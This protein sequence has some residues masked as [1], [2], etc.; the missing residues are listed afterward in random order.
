MRRIFILIACLFAAPAWGF[1]TKAGPLEIV[2]DGNGQKHLRVGSKAY[3][4]PTEPSLAF[5]EAQFDDW[6]LILVSQGGNAC[7]G[8]YLWFHAVPGE[9]GF[10]PDFGTC[11]EAAEVSRRA[12]GT[13]AVTMPRASAGA[14]PVTYLWDGR[15]L[16][17][18]DAARPVSGAAPGQGA[19]YWID[20]YPFD[21]LAAADYQDRIAAAMDDTARAELARVMELASPFEAE[22]AWIVGAGCVKAACDSDRAVIALAR[23]DGRIVVALRSPALGAQLFGNPGGPLPA[24]IVDLLARQ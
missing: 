15:Q 18:E 23:D 8:R 12:D 9:L 19:E 2:E 14:P 20:L 4:L 16:R 11:A 5:L 7:N 24:S 10:S 3:V 21:L 22:G 1:D 6:V 13:L 17:E